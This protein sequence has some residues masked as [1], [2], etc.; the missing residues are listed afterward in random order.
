MDM[1][2]TGT[3]CAS[4]DEGETLKEEMISE[5][6]KLAEEKMAADRAVLQQSLQRDG[7]TD[8]EA[9]A[10]A[11]VVV[12]LR[13][14]RAALDEL[15]KVARENL[16]AILSAPLQTTVY[17]GRTRLSLGDIPIDRMGD[18]RDVE[19]S[20]EQAVLEA[21]LRKCNS[22]RSSILTNIAE[23]EEPH[24][25]SSP[26]L[27]EIPTIMPELWKSAVD[28]IRRAAGVAHVEAVASSVDSRRTVESGL[29]KEE[30]L[31]VFDRAWDRTVLQHVHEDDE[32]GGDMKEPVL[33][34]NVA[35]G[36]EAKVGRII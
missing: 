22:S 5:E 17:R 13:A 20:L 10:A 9:A 2:L 4:K 11:S 33:S 15:E 26:R 21:L 36:Y 3:G 31:A 27:T 28:K 23:E 1:M 14:R 16:E 29:T 34:G 24:D 12:R 18:S 6:E 7:M 32:E 25:F 8:V 35:I 19:R 30:F